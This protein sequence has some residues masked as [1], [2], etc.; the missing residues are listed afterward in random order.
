M[1]LLTDEGLEGIGE[2]TA[3][4]QAGGEDCQIRLIENRESSVSPESRSEP[5][6]IPHNSTYGH[7]I[8]LEEQWNEV[9]L[10]FH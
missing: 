5:L 4:A 1:K 6:S 3:G 9:E 8:E 7:D 2:W 10:S